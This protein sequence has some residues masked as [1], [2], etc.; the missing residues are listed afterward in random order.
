MKHHS[1]FAFV[2]LFVIALSGCG[3]KNPYDT[4]KASGKVTVDGA[5]MQGIT[6]TFT[7]E[8]GDGQIAFGSTDAQGKFVL[9]TPGA[10]HGS[11]ALAGTYIPTFSKTE[12]E[13]QP[14][15]AT[16][17]EQ[18]QR[19]PPKTIYLIPKEYENP[20]TCGINPVTVAKGQK[21]VFEFELK[22]SK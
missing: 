15:A 19:E 8:S 1:I 7:S 18:A 20:K 2:F 13:S 10:P 9:S 11:G 3:E 17:E 12:T 5:P 4:I 21:N 6:V 16:P 14:P 22:S